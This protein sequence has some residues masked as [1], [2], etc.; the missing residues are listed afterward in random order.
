MQAIAQALVPETSHPAGEKAQARIVTRGKMLKLQFKAQDSSSLRA[1]MSSYLRMLRATV[2]VSKSILE[3]ERRHDG[4]HAKEVAAKG[5]RS[6][7]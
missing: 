2:T 3:L 1:I 4:K 5:G 6:R 7:K